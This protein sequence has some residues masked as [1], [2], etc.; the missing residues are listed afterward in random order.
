[1]ENLNQSVLDAALRSVA[2]ERVNNRNDITVLKNNTVRILANYKK[3][4]EADKIKHKA[5]I[6]KHKTDGMLTVD[7]TLENKK[8]EYGNKLKSSVTTIT[9]NVNS[10]ISD[11]N[12]IHT[13]NINKIISMQNAIA[14]DSLLNIN[15][16]NTIGIGNNTDG[17]ILGKDILLKDEIVLG[18]PEGS[19]FA[20][21]Y[22]DGDICDCIG[23]NNPDGIES[24]EQY[25]GTGTFHNADNTLCGQ[26]IIGEGCWFGIGGDNIFY[27][28]YSDKHWATLALKK[29]N[30]ITVITSGPH[31]AFQESY[32]PTYKPVIYT[33]DMFL[34]SGILTNHT[35]YM[36]NMYTDKFKQATIFN[37]NIRYIADMYLLHTGLTHIPTYESTHLEYTYI[38]LMVSES[39]IVTPYILNKRKETNI[40]YQDI[41]EEVV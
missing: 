26:M 25:T 34:K 11:L 13:S 28:M 29:I 31:I 23:N 27:N 37:R 18:L 38:K 17:Y 32:I 10:K 22:L 19:I 8:I 16:S 30:D 5:N 9:G 2:L 39:D 36:H 33:F 24:V 4:V 12:T 40:T 21:N 7:S 1:M 20:V 41:T 35:Y 3:S 14:N 6:T 15:V